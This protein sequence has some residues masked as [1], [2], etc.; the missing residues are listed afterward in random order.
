MLMPKTNN[1]NVL[2]L[3]SGEEENPSEEEQAAEKPDPFPQHKGKLFDISNAQED[4]NGTKNTN[5]G[6]GLEILRSGL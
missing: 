6:G 2:F 3:S 5:G 1:N 4:Y